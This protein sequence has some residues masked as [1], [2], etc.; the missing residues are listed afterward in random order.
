MKTKSTGLLV[1][2]C[3]AV[4]LGILFVACQPRSGETNESTTAGTAIQKQLSQYIRITPTTDLSAFSERDQQMTPLLIEAAQ[5]M[6]D[7]FWRQ[8]YGDKEALLAGIGNA[9]VRRYVEI[10]YG[11]WDRLEEDR[12][13]IDGVGA[14]P[15]G[16]G[17]YPPDMAPE[18]LE[19]AA[20]ADP[21]LGKRL[22]DPYTVVHRDASGGLTA[23]PYSREY[24][25]EFRVAAEKLRAAAA[26]ADDDGLRRY[27]ELRATAL[28]SDDY[29]ASDMAWMDMKN[30]AVEVVIGPIETYEDQLFGVKP[31]NEA[32]VLIKDQEWSRWLS[33]VTAMLP[34]VQRGLPVPDRY[35][36]EEP[37]TDPDLNAYDVV[38]YAGHC[39]AGSKHIAI[40]LPNDERVQ[41]EKGIR[42]ML[43]KN[44]IRAK[45]DRIMIPIAA[46][47]IAADQRRHVTFDAA[48][49]NFLFH[50]VAR[51]LGIR[52][53]V[54]GRG[55]VWEALGERA[56]E[57]DEGKAVVLGLYLASTLLAE[58]ELGDADLMD[59]YTTSLANVLRSI[60]YGPTPAGMANLIGFNSFQEMGAFRRDQATGTYR[61]D[62]DRMDAAIKALAER[63][64]VLQGEGDFDAVAA[65]IEQYG[66]RDAT[67]SADIERLAAAGVPHEPHPRQIQR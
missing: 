53:T 32:Y 48:L 33:K 46:E 59:Y 18:E 65:F 28:E 27:L 39:N 26:L 5:A 49:R 15:A 24:A 21:E 7:A 20:A 31:A 29:L 36:Q 10:N 44:A 2:G 12:P 1:L 64:L 6:D 54:S 9:D 37:D 17:F 25:V 30:N 58:D 34:A 3:C 60:R 45:F 13:F 61:V 40:F 35:K 14:K 63:L 19:Q 16:A 56:V 47:L 42:R 41:R 43:L 8:A 52:Q 23:V 51:G 11:P 55:T 67:L 62:P 22:L 57:I 38:H 66:E 4:L 50:E